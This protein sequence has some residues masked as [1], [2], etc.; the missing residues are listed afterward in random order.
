M[1]WFGLVWYELVNFGNFQK[2]IEFFGNFQKVSYQTIPNQII[3]NQT[4][5]L[6][7]YKNLKKSSI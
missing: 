4:N 6:E 1:V 3:P 7:I 2:K 5:F